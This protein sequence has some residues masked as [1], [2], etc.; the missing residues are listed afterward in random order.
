MGAVAVVARRRFAGRWRALLA[1]GLL[2]GIGYGVSMASFAAARRT[3]S[4]YDRLL[5][6]SDAPDASVALGPSIDA[7]IRSLGAIPGVTRQR[8]QAGY[9]GRVDGVEP[10]YSTALLAPTSDAFPVQRPH[11]EA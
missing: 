11:V 6:A 4:A 9:L 3:A 7:S 5:V 1:A 10:V 8:A 2:L